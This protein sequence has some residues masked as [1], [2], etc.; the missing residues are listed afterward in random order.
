MT[1]NTHSCKESFNRLRQ[2][3]ASAANAQGLMHKLDFEENIMAQHGGKASL[4][5]ALIRILE[6]NVPHVEPHVVLAATLLTL[7][8]GMVNEHQ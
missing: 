5:A 8:P 7:P 4:N 2:K 3:F 1:N 6:E